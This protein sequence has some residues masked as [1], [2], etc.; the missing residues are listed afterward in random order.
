[1][2]LRSG[3]STSRSGNDVSHINFAFLA[4]EGGQ[5]Y[6]ARLNAGQPFGEMT[7]L[8]GRKGDGPAPLKFP[9]GIIN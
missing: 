3:N 6:F 2:T 7:G 5:P 9:A 4:W 1:M 8:P